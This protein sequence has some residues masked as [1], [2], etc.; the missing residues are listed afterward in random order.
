M[1]TEA[2]I[3]GFLAR[4]GKITTCKPGAKSKRVQT[5]FDFSSW[6]YDALKARIYELEDIGSEWIL[7]DEDYDRRTR[8]FKKLCKELDALRLELSKRPKPN[9]KSNNPEGVWFV[10]DEDGDDYR[11]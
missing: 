11:K 4:G 9:N 10:S 5:S 1:P 2:E 3:Q 6:S 7:C 8:A